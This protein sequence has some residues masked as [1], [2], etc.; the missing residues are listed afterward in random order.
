LTGPTGDAGLDEILSVNETW[1]YTCAVKLAIDTTNKATVEYPGG[2]KEATKFVDVINPGIHVSKV[3]DKTTIYSGT[4]VTY[5]YKV[6]N[7]G[8]D[9]LLNVSLKDDICGPAV[10]LAG[11]V[12][13]NSKLDKPEEWTY[14]C[15]QTLTDAKVN[16]EPNTVLNTVTAT[17]VD[18]LE[19]T[20]SSDK[21]T[22][23][24]VII[25][26]SIALRKSASAS[27]VHTG[28]VVTYTFVVSNTG[29]S[30][31]SNVTVVDDNCK[32]LL[33]PVGDVNGNTKFDVGELWTFTCTQALSVSTVN[34]ARANGR[35]QF[36]NAVGEKTA[37]ATV[38]VIDPAIAIA[39]S[40][41]ST[42]IV[43]GAS[44]TYTYKVTN[45]GDV[46]LSRIVV[47]DDKCSP[48]SV[49]SGDSNNNSKLE[50]TETWTYTCNQTIA[51]TTT[52]I[53]TVRAIDP[54]EKSVTAQ[55]KVTVTA[56]PPV[57]TSTT[58]V[59]AT[60]STSSTS[61]TTSTLAP[62]VAP[63]T[64]STTSTT[65][66]LAP[67]SAALV[68]PGVPQP[69]ISP[70]P[71]TTLPAAAFPAVGVVPASVLAGNLPEAP[72]PNVLGVQVSK[73]EPAFTGSGS[74]TQ[75]LGFV[76]SVAL[77]L[78]YFLLLGLSMRRRSV[79]R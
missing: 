17:G 64:P 49:P 54:L 72:T 62:T 46:A 9:P 39:K 58:V 51:V 3:A 63:T 36:D 32:P 20:V 11:D 1:S 19:G 70:A 30:P 26:P 7:S 61:S 27:T 59:P 2:V 40:A 73:T 35:D 57:T 38:T 4:S 76:G 65:T 18:R 28:D 43:Q 25:H 48:L 31:V 50:N 75:L 10:Y 68:F 78:G 42:A 56:R 15:K 8:D 77:L 23:S 37:T 12:N 33:G 21:A 5:T 29:D 24:V 55:A 6:T 52:N 71:L 53:A 16:V 14:T 41:S 44:V 22:A 69:S 79:D 13:A 47:S 34:V 67:L 45:M 60:T 74:T 66:A